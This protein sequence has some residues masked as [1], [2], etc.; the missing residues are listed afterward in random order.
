[1][2]GIA[3]VVL[4]CN[5]VW[6]DNFCLQE[7]ARSCFLT[8]AHISLGAVHQGLYSLSS[9]TSYRQSLEAARLDI[10]MIVSI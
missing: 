1:M 9:K 7:N 10:M 5:P 4:L 8:K 3:I 2:N 6:P